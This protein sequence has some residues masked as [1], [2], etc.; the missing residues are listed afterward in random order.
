MQRAADECREPS[1][2]ID[3]SMGCRYGQPVPFWGW[4]GEETAH[5]WT[6]RKYQASFLQL[7][8]NECPFPNSA[9]MNTALNA[10]I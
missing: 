6:A 8:M 9:P 5:V 2:T 1:Y 3:R 4:Y 10:R 7:M